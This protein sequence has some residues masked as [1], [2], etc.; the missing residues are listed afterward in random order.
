MIY[1]FRFVICFLVWNNR[2]IILLTNIVANIRN[3]T[4][5]NEITTINNIREKRLRT[6]K[7]RLA[8]Q[9]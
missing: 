7:F 3:T 9:V 5:V 1:K 2:T 8:P 6:V 4:S